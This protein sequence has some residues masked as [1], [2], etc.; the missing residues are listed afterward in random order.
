MDCRLLRPLVT[1]PRP[2]Q[3]W[4][5]AKSVFFRPPHTAAELAIGSCHSSLLFSR[6]FASTRTTSSSGSRTKRK[7]STNRKRSQTDAASSSPSSA[8]SSSPPSSSTTTPAPDV[9][10]G[11]TL[12]AVILYPHPP[13]I[14]AF[15][16]PTPNY[17][18][19]VK[20]CYQGEITAER[21]PSTARTTTAAAAAGTTTSTA[22]AAGAAADEPLPYECTCFPSTARVSMCVCVYVCAGGVCHSCFC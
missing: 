8:S 13:R 17:Y 7:A 9:P 12:S 18:Y 14:K 10:D 19:L 16:D 5:H 1:Q 4:P 15:Q 2:Q 20:A 3:P 22:G 6:S 21:L 11:L